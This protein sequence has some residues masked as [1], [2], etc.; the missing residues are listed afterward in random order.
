[1]VLCE[2]GPQE[3][4]DCSRKCYPVRGWV[5]RK[6]ESAGLPTSCLPLFLISGLV[7]HMPLTFLKFHTLFGSKP[8]MDAK[9]MGESVWLLARSLNSLKVLDLSSKDE[10][11]LIRLL[12]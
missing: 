3:I 11:K 6:N 7:P 2:F 8:S 10:H 9:A 4:M 1:M 5:K 12:M